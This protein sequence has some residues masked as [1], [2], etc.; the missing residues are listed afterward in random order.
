[1]LSW[2]RNQL[3][4]NSL[5]NTR[6]W[7]KAISRIMM[8]KSR[9]NN[10]SDK[11]RCFTLGSWNSTRWVGFQKTTEKKNKRDETSSDYKLKMWLTKAKRF[12]KLILI[13][14]EKWKYE[15]I[16]SSSKYYRNVFSLISS[17]NAARLVNRRKS[18]TDYNVSV[19]LL[20]GFLQIVK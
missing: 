7:T 11:S 3:F 16:L 12:F 9:H 5:L 18:W 19:L 20:A 13:L 15:I 4:K 1:M 8:K 6:A 14:F 17:N 2:Q 10:C